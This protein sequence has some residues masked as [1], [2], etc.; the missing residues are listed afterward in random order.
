M[1]VS[2]LTM[3]AQL[4]V[5]LTSGAKSPTG[6]ASASTGG[7]SSSSPR[8]V[9][10]F[11]VRDFIPGGSSSADPSA[12]VEP[13]VSPSISVRTALSGIDGVVDCHQLATERVAG[14]AELPATLALASSPT[15][16]YDGEF[17]R[18]SSFSDAC[19]NLPKA[20]MD[21]PFSEL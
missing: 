11:T 18:R 17:L 1:I 19:E 2:Y 3:I 16:V 20:L 8:T 15:C 9:L 10:V 21:F 6:S 7:Q 4:G 5:V 14:A 12:P 13:A